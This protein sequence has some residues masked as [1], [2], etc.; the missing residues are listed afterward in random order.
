M[1]LRSFCSIP[2]GTDTA[3]ATTWR[4]APP[5]SD[6]TIS[7]RPG[8]PERLPDFPAFLSAEEVAERGV[9][10]L[11]RGAPIIVTHAG[12]KPLVE[13][14]FGRFLAAYDDSAQFENRFGA[15]ADSIAIT[16]GDGVERR[17]RGRAAARPVRPG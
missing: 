12:M 9:D 3:I 13:E 8:C 11:R 5:G 7:P 14:Y 6:T 4:K 16:S 1:E 17:A 15:P 10:G 2:A